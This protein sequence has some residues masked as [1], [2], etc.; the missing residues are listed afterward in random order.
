MRYFPVHEQPDI[1]QAQT[2]A[3][4]GHYLVA[5]CERLQPG[6]LQLTLATTLKSVIE[7]IRDSRLSH[8]TLVYKYVPKAMPEGIKDLKVQLEQTEEEPIFDDSSTVVRGTAGFIPG[9]LLRNV[10]RM[11]KRALERLDRIIKID[12]DGGRYA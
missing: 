5:Q 6:E 3:K 4:Q 12:K 2:M 8:L 9:P 7:P 1:Q 11:D 10:L